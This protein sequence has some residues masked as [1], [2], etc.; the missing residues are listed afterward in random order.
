MTENET[1][2]ANEEAL[3]GTPG[4]EAAHAAKIQEWIDAAPEFRPEATAEELVDEFKNS[5]NRMPAFLALYSRGDEVL[6]AVRDGLKHANWNVRRWCALFADNFADAETLKALVPLL[7]DPKAKVRVWAVH[8][9]S[10]DTCKDGPNPVDAIPLLL[11]RIELDE[12]IKVRRHATAMLAAHK[13][14]DPR[15]LP[16]FEQILREEDDRKLR[17]HAEHGIKRYAELG[18]RGG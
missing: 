18:L 7:R 15:V 4:L 9:L 12:S 10:C 13:S 5:E 16:V 8:S 14:P 3:C 6:P 1:T 2:N 11:E 17:L